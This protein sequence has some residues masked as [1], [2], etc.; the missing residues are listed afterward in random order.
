MNP[1]ILWACAGLVFVSGICLLFYFSQSSKA[2]NDSLMVSSNP[3]QAYSEKN[4][5]T[6]SAENKQATEKNQQNRDQTVFFVDVKGAVQHSQVVKMKSG[7][8]IQSALNLAGGVN[9]DADLN[10]LN[11]AAAAT[12]GQVIYVPKKGEKIPA[13]F[14]APSVEE[15]AFANTA[16]LETSNGNTGESKIDLNQAD[17][18]RLQTISGIGEKKADDIIKYRDEHGRFKKIEDLQNVSGFGEK[19][20]EKL[21]DYVTVQ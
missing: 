19:T 8:I 15:N 17:A 4:S 11:L 21:K 6:G 14:A 3:A 16:S 5:Q 7:E 13:Q 2:E 12:P 9:A 10:Q 1:K 18:S 20:V